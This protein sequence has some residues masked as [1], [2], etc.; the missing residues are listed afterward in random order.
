MVIVLIIKLH[1]LLY[2]LYITII[3]RTINF[4]GSMEKEDL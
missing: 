4:V 1:N 2:I 3:I